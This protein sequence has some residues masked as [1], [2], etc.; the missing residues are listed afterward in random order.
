MVPWLI[1][2]WIYLACQKIYLKGS[3]T[4]FQEKRFN[5]GH[6]VNE[7][8]CYWNSSFKLVLLFL[9]KNFFHKTSGKKSFYEIFHGN[10]QI[11]SWPTQNDNERRQ[12]NLW[13]NKYFHVPLIFYS[14]NHCSTHIINNYFPALCSN[15][16]Y[17]YDF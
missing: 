12:G 5:V 2:H 1:E 11:P 10:S 9:P 17:S 4:L 6:S 14:E 15:I 16:D 13:G 8:N 3:R 7:F